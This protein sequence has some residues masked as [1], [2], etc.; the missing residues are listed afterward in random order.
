[1]RGIE[2]SLREEMLVMRLSALSTSPALKDAMMALRAC[3]IVSDS[4][5]W[6]VIASVAR[7]WTT[8]QLELAATSIQG[9]SVCIHV[10]ECECECIC[11]GMCVSTTSRVD[12][13]KSWD[14]TSTTSK[15]KTSAYLPILCQRVLT[16]LPV[17]VLA[18][19]DAVLVFPLVA[20]VAVSV[21]EHTLQTRWIA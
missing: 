1:M 15:A 12:Q 2:S 4:L 5:A 11:I 17:L 13:D 21:L 7:P 14:Y 18:N 16:R 10:C 19:A 20:V 8:T 9:T 6:S 3:A